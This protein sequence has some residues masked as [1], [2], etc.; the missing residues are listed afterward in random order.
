MTL[1]TDKTGRPGP[2][3]WEAEDYPDGQDDYPVPGSAGMKQ[4]LTP[5]MREKVSQ[6]RSLGQ[7][8]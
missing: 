7:R 6:P 1:F 2:S 3:T 4:Q 5:N 8:G